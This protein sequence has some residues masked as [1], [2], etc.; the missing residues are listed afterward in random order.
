MISDEIVLSRLSDLVAD[1]LELNELKL[2]RATRAND[3]EG[4]DSFAH[5][6]ILIAAE[7]AFGVQFTTAE[8]ASLDT[9]GDLVNLIQARSAG[10]S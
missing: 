2:T 6:R 4:W 9:V 1:L 10:S 3:V 7:Q 8:I 5:V